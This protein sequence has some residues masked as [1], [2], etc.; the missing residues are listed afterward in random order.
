MGA[1]IAKCPKLTRKIERAVASARG[2]VAHAHARLAHSRPVYGVLHLTNSDRRQFRE[3][4]TPRYAWQNR[5][6]CGTL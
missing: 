6:D 5:K 4:E 3:V 2:A 1:R